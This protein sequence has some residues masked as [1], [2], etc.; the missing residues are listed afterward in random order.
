ML[1]D[2]VP[3]KFMIGKSLTFTIYIMLHGWL[4]I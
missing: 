4:D 2:S 1:H 3:H